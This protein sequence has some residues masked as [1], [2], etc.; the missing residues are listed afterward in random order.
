MCRSRY[1]GVLCTPLPERL[2]PYPA[3]L[4]WHASWMGAASRGWLQHRASKDELA[5]CTLSSGARLPPRVAVHDM[6]CTRCMFVRET[7]PPRVQAVAITGD[8]KAHTLHT[9]VTGCS[10]EG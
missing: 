9:H 5:W 3:H 8:H 6:V 10:G 7:K 1:T 4:R 2:A